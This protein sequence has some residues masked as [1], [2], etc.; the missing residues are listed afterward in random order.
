VGYRQGRTTGRICDPYGDVFLIV[1]GWQTL[2]QDFADLEPRVTE[3]AA[4]GLAF[5]V[6]VVVAANRWSE[7]RPSIRDLL[8]AKL[9][10]RLGD[11]MESELGAKVAARVPEQA[12]RGLTSTKFH[13][14][15]GLPR[16]DSSSQTGDLT[17]ATKAAVE[18]IA[19]FWTGPTAPE[20]RLLPTRLPAAQLPAPDGDVRICLGID[21]QRLAAVWHDF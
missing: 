2:R 18:E 15:A 11:P 3:L 13:F 10:L 19:T 7:G 5:G 4:R 8:G 6:H 14:L 16:I 20:V 12:G 21:E 1:D 17:T 9:E